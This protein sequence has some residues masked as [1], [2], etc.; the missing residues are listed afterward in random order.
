MGLGQTGTFE[1]WRFDG[2]VGAISTAET[3]LAFHAVSHTGSGGTGNTEGRLIRVIEN[4]PPAVKIT[5]PL[6][7]ASASVGQTV[8][9]IAELA[10]DTLGIGLSVA[11]YLNGEAVDLF[12]YEDAEKRFA[13]SFG[14]QKAS[15]T[16]AVPVVAEMLG[17]SL[18]FHL[19]AVDFHGLVS[20]S[21]E[22][23]LPVKA[24]QPPNV[25]ISNPVD[26]ASFI[27]GLPIEIRADATDDIH[28]QRV[29][30]YVADRLA[31]SDT[32]YPYSFQYETLEGLA[33]EQSLKIFAIAIDSRSQQ[34]RSADVF[35]TLG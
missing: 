1:I 15:H 17:T 12:R 26:G 13:G 18:R 28:V 24:D 30:F 3:S 34:A 4:S 16:F 33:R 27:S 9:L 20:K 7:G 10:D 22:L 31:G 29:D 6:P 2:L 19:E 25:A 5:A 21:E 32:R 23:V 35:V 11:L 8:D 14:V